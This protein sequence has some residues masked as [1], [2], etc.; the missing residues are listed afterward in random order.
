MPDDRAHSAQRS[1][2]P[3][4]QRAR[5]RCL[6]ALE[7]LGTT[8]RITATTPHP[9]QPK[10][11]QLRSGRRVVA[12]LGASLVEALEAD[13]GPLVGARIEGALAQAIVE[14]VERDA[15]RREALRRLN[16]RPLLS[17][18]LATALRRQGFSQAAVQ[19]AL[20][21][22]AAIGALDDHATAK[23]HAEAALAKQPLGARG[24]VAALQRRGADPQLARDIAQE[25]LTGHDEREDA[26]VAA[27]RRARALQRLPLET[28]QRRLLAYLQRRGFSLE[29]SLEAV[30][31]A[32]DGPHEPS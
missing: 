3:R 12:T 5:E 17:G 6:R 27:R 32:L 28:A 10:R 16:R 24:L 2:L 7:A 20:A 18:A 26:T 25:T 1:R 31:N 11:V 29:I 21:H 14:Q 13:H 22:C 23:A 4:A 15:A 9:S 30:R 19:D 8:A